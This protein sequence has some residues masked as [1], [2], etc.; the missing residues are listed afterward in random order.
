VVA[1]R[2]ESKAFQS[3]ITIRCSRSRLPERVDISELAGRLQPV[4]HAATTS[5]FVAGLAVVPASRA[6][7]HWAARAAAIIAS[8]EQKAL[9]IR[10]A[11]D[12]HEARHKDGQR[13]V[14]F[15]PATKA[16]VKRL[17]LGGGGSSI[18]V[19]HG[20]DRVDGTGG[21]AVDRLRPARNV[22]AALGFAR[23]E[24]AL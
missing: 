22:V 5:R 2:S 7:G 14:G 1:G 6:A 16:R 24:I 4:A 10:Y 19:T 12:A 17:R 18:A 3:L 11:V 21:R 13:V 23:I 8:D 9:Y 20:A 15:N